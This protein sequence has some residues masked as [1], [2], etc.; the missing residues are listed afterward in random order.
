MVDSTQSILGER[1]H[2]VEPHYA[3]RLRACFR[4][5]QN[6]ALTTVDTGW[7]LGDL[8]DISARGVTILTRR[9]FDQG[10]RLVIEP[11]IQPWDVVQ[12]LSARVADVQVFEGKFRVGCELELPLSD[13][14]LAFLV[15]ANRSSSG[16]AT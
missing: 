9:A 4:E 6:R 7:R 12:Q 15:A 1:E 8:V 10:A 5:Q 16:R 2:K 3:C 14:E 13:A 11:L